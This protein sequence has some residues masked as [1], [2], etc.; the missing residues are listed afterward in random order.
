MILNRRGGRVVEGAR[1]E[2]VYRG[3]PTVSSNLTL[4]A[5]TLNNL[6]TTLERFSQS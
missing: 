1:L 4:S 5:K 3:N 6:H 2:S